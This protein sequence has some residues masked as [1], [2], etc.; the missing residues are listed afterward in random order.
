MLTIYI[1]PRHPRFVVS[2]ESILIGKSQVR[3]GDDFSIR[4]LRQCLHAV[5]R[6]IERCEII[7]C[8]IHTKFTVGKTGVF[9]CT[10][11]SYDVP[12]AEL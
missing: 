6:N 9:N 3:N 12:G 2:R 5:V 1:I 8:A 4:L 7:H 11:A 10:M